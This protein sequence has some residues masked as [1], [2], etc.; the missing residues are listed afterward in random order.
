MERRAKLAKPVAL[1]DSVQRRLEKYALAA[2]AAG[3]GAMALGAPAEGKVIYS[4]GTHVVGHNQT[5]NF[6]TDH[7][8]IPEFKLVNGYGCS[9]VCFGALFALPAGHQDGVEGN[10][11]KGFFLTHKCA[12]PL[13]TGAIIGPNQPFSGGLLFSEAS[14]GGQWYNVKSAYLGLRFRIDGKVH[15]GWAHLKM[16]IPQFTMTLDGYAYETVAGRPIEA[17]AKGDEWTPP[18]QALG[19][20]A[21]GRR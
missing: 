7:F 21:V 19:G 13:K 6:A 12:Y 20:L 15:Y 4:P 5:Y 8:L 11:C 10:F 9:D 17:G 3:V 16:D 2:S 14:S 1:S 18:A